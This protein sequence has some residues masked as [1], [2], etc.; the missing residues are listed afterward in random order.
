MPTRDEMKQWEMAK[1]Y[2]DDPRVRF[3]IGDIPAVGTVSIVRSTGSIMSSWPPP[4]P[5]L[6]PTAEFG[7]FECV[8]RPTSR[9]LMNLDRCPY[10]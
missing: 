10:R 5:R 6:S 8:T 1:G 7:P 2:K 9:A 4:P 3:L